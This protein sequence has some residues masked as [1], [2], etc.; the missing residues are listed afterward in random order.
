M[1]QLLRINRGVEST[2]RVI[3]IAGKVVEKST[4]SHT[5]NLDKF[6]GENQAFTLVVKIL[7]ILHRAKRL[8][9]RTDSLNL[10]IVVTR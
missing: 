3:S 4:K 8:D 5:N 9:Y 10:M 7:R 2:F 1:I 6:E